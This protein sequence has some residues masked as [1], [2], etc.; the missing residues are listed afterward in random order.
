MGNTN[1]IF[2]AVDDGPADQ[3]IKTIECWAD[4][5]V[6]DFNLSSN[7]N[8]PDQQNIANMCCSY[9]NQSQLHVVFNNRDGEIFHENINNGKGWVPINSLLPFSIHETLS[10]SIC[11]AINKSDPNGRVHVFA[12]S[13]N[14]SIF[15]TYGGFPPFATTTLIK[16]KEAWQ[17]RWDRIPFSGAVDV[18][19]R[20]RLSAAFDLYGNLHLF[21]IDS[22]LVLW[23]NLRDTSGHWQSWDKVPTETSTGSTLR[24][25]TSISAATST[26]HAIHLCAVDI[27]GLLFYKTFVAYYSD[28]LPWSN[29]TKEIR[30]ANVSP[31]KD[32]TNIFRVVISSD[33]EDNI[34]IVAIPGGIL[35]WGPIYTKR[36]GHGVVPAVYTPL[37]NVL[38]DMNFDLGASVGFAHN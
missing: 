30:D 8:V 4:D 3:P 36:S 1:S 27:N 32:L 33:E 7:L 31:G 9:D 10:G 11:C 12:V 35:G 37:V 29:V 26:S 22:V 14:G 24:N 2:V 34:H 19:R 20:L 25:F 15:H 13:D 17:F 21:V 28:S 16:F 6:T 5:P 38:P 23:H 18:P